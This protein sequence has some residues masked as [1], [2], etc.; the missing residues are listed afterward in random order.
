[1]HVEHGRIERGCVRGD[2]R[3]HYKH[4]RTIEKNWVLFAP[5][6]TAADN[7]SIHC[8]YSWSPLVVGIIDVDVNE[9]SQMFTEIHRTTN[10]PNFFSF[11]RGSANGITITSSDDDGTD[12]IWFLC[13]L[14]S[15]EY[16]RF[17]YH[18]IVVLD[19]VTL[20]IKKYTSL[21][22][23]HANAKVEYSLGFMPMDRNSSQFLIGY[24]VN[25]EETKYMT[26]LRN[27]LEQKMITY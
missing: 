13:H 14:V 19:G 26:V 17:Y 12:E 25:D 6:T 23:F 18:L 22:T 21:W 3:L 11:V 1:M 20:A 2:S 7:A 24:S 8:I 9:G 5:S 16:R 4:E 10:V 15:Y 27:I